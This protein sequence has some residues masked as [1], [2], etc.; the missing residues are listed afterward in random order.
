MK[1]NKFKKVGFDNKKRVFHLEYTTG[2]KIDC[3]YSALCIRDKVIEA[4][5]DPEG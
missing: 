5:P 2:L 3:P 4:G 1:H